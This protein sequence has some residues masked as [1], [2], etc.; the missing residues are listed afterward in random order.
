M[1]MARDLAGKSS[2]ERSS[3]SSVEWNDSITALSRVVE[4]S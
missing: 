3:N 1:T 4:C 2:T